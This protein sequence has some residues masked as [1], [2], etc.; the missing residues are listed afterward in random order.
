MA[1]LIKKP[2]LHNNSYRLINN[3]RCQMRRGG[4]KFLKQV[5]NIDRHNLCMHNINKQEK[6]L[7]IGGEMKEFKAGSF[8]RVYDSENGK[9]LWEYLNEIK[10]D[11]EIASKLKRPAVEAIDEDELL[12]MFNNWVEALQVRQMIGR[13]VLQ[14]MDEIG[15]E[16]ENERCAIHHNKLFS[17]ATRYVKKST[18]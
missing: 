1:E 3:K 5:K 11:F 15:Y 6:R 12:K 8:S 10:H 2:F 16:K 9:K 7:N 13:M 4:R 14:I 18:Q 17:K